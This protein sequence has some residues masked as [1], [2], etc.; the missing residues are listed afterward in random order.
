MLPPAG[1]VFVQA[2]AM[3]AVIKKSVVSWSY[4]QEW[5]TKQ[6]KMIY[7][8]VAFETVAQALLSV[9]QVLVQKAE[10]PTDKAIWEAAKMKK[11]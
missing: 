1:F 3:M 6:R 10:Y 11:L 5:V 9:S 8:C 4:S 2:E 7:W